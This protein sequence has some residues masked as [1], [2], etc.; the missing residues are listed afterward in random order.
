M[1]RRF[2]G[3]WA[4]AAGALLIGGT[5]IGAAQSNAPIA[6]AN[7]PPQHDVNALDQYSAGASQFLKVP[8]VK[9]IPGAIAPPPSIKNPAANDPAAAERGMQYFVKFN[10]VG[11]HAANG[12]GGMGPA[13][14]N[15]FFK[16]GSNPANIFVVI[17]HG[18]PLG[19]PSWGGVLPEQAIWD[20]VAY[21]QSISNAPKEQ[22]GTTVSPAADMPAIQQVPAEFK[23][24]ATPW[25]FTEPFGN[26]Q[27]PAGSAA[28]MAGRAAPPSSGSSKP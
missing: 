10:C 18:M 16:F 11:C 7:A 27:A 12:G 3:S 4:I 13:L 1:A 14:S 9:N 24:T 19:M 6:P 20:L 28:G 17:S 2:R 21:I 5:T 25:Q 15:T 26:G 22:W 8:L 23:Q